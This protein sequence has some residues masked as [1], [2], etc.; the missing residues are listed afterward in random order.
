MSGT[1][2]MERLQTFLLYAKSAGAKNRMLSEVKKVSRQGG[3]ESRQVA[4]D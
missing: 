1:G 4:E 3:K 2:A